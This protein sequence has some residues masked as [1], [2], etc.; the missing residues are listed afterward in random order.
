M[1]LF[2]WVFLSFVVFSASDIFRFLFPKRKRCCFS[3]LGFHIEYPEWY[4]FVG[5]SFVCCFCGVCLFPCLFLFVC[6]FCCS[7]LLLFF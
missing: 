5:V 6:L 2:L 7:G 4:L 1:I 3:H